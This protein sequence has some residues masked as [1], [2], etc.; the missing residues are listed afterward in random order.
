MKL[1]ISTNF[2]VALVLSVFTL[3]ASAD[4]PKNCSY[5]KNPIIC[6]VE[7]DEPY[8][9]AKVSCDGGVKGTAV[10]ELV[11]NKCPDAEACV[12]DPTDT[13]L[14]QSRLAQNNLMNRAGCALFATGNDAPPPNRTPAPTP[15]APPVAPPRGGGGGR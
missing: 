12:S 14:Q 6:R 9:F 2:F 5:D 1:L 13:D 8:C 4:E 10:C 15:V 3:S 11:D 7:V